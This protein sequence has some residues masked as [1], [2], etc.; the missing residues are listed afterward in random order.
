[1]KAKAK[2]LI[3]GLF[4]GSMGAFPLGINVGR[5]APLFSNP[6]AKADLHDRVI[7]RVRSGTDAALEGARGTI[8]EATRPLPQ[9]N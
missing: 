6:F 9:T 8:H 4:L 5:G 3:L 2:L 1:M 7:E